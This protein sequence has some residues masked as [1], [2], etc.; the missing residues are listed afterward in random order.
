MWAFAGTFTGTLTRVKVMTVQ[1]L[2]GLLGFLKDELMYET[3]ITGQIILW[4]LLYVGPGTR[5]RMRQESHLG[6]KV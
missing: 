1:A 4:A 3:L 6:R 2:G 5:T